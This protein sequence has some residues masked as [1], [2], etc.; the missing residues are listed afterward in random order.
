MHIDVCVLVCGAD[1]FE[2]YE[3]LVS[4]VVFVESIDNE[5]ELLEGF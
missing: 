3:H 1:L 5:Y 4:E 2:R